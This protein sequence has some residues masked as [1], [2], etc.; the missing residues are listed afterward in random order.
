MNLGGIKVKHLLQMFADH[1]YHP[2]I[3]WNQINV[4]LICIC[5]PAQWR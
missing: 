5:R 2:R 1:C 4:V 3:L